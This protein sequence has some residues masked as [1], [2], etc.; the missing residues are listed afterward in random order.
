MTTANEAHTDELMQEVAAPELPQLE[1]ALATEEALDNSTMQG[2]VTVE[3]QTIEDHKD[4]A[5]ASGED[6]PPQVPTV[7]D[8]APRALS[9]YPVLPAQMTFAELIPRTAFGLDMINPGLSANENITDLVQG[10]WPG[11]RKDRRIASEVTPAV[12]AMVECSRSTHDLRVFEVDVDQ[13]EDAP[14]TRGINTAILESEFK[15]MIL[16][17]QPLYPTEPTEDLAPDHFHFI[18]RSEQEGVRAA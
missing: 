2:D 14:P 1:K 3:R 8:H 17:Y 7:D 11:C 15:G 12:T 9:D 6:A 18:R 4:S 5:M 13:G 16:L 10:Y